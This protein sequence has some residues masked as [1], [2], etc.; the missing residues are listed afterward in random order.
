[1]PARAQRIGWGCD[2]PAR[3]GDGRLIVRVHPLR[4]TGRLLL[5]VWPPAPVCVLRL[6]RTVPYICAHLTCLT[7]TLHVIYDIPQP[8][9]ARLV[10]FEMQITKGL[11]PGATALAHE[12]VRLLSTLTGQ[13]RLSFISSSLSRRGAACSSGAGAPVDC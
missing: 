8:S 11:R 10:A 4:G 9:S 12:L 6:A 5:A 13:Q 1:M 2:A 3:G 7:C